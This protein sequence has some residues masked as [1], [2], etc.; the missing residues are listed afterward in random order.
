MREWKSGG[1]MI[2]GRIRQKSERV[3]RR[4]VRERKVRLRKIVQLGGRRENKEQQR[5]DRR[6]LKLLQRTTP[7][8]GRAGEGVE[9]Q[10][11]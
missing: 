6:G 3:R 1:G 9:N 11:E 7:N 4:G 10:L 8:Q 2:R 5:T